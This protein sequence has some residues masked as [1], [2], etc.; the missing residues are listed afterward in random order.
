VTAPPAALSRSE[1]LRKRREF[2]AVQGR[3]RKFH[4]EYFVVF[5][6]PHPDDA[7]TRVGFTVSKKVGSAVVRNR[8]KRLAR[9]AY[10]RYKTQ[11]PAGADLVFVAKRGAAMMSYQAAER[12]IDKL[13]TRYFARR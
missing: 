6:L 12:D 13:C 3:G 2:L 7:S 9:E 8:V 11:F 4:T 1:R 5:L 10:R